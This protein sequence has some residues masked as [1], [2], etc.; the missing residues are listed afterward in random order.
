M[1]GFLLDA[2]HA[3]KLVGRA[4]PMR[5]RVLLAPRPVHLCPVVRSEVRFGLLRKRMTNA[6]REWDRFSA[7]LPPLPLDARDADRAADLR[8]EQERLGRRLELPDALIAA[9]ALRHDLTLLTADRDF[10]AVPG[11]TVEDWLAP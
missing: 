5:G 8:A 10:G 7:A 11:L 3:G 2:N 4:H 1:N 6:L 9:V